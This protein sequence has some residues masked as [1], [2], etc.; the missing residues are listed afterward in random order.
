M[1]FDIL[2]ALFL[3]YG[4]YKGFSKGLINSFMAIFTYLLGF[5]LALKCSFPILQ[6]ITL[7]FNINPKI[8]PLLSFILA[9]SLV[10][11]VC[12]VILFFVEKALN[13]TKLNFLNKQLGALVWT[14]LVVLVFSVIVWIMDGSNLWSESAK[15]GSVVYPFLS[16]IAPTAIELLKNT[17]PFLKESFEKLDNFFDDKIII[18]TQSQ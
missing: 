3:I 6:K 16:K 11:L 15:K 18:T 4:F 2:F 9:F 5:S 13:A 12:Q 7:H 14:I 17:I 8:A 10:V 1:F